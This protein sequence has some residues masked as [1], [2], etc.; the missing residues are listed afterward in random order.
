[1]KII[2]AKNDL[3]STL[4]TCQA[5]VVK[6]ASDLSGQYLFRIQP[7]SKDQ[8]E[9]LTYADRCN[10]LAQLKCQ[11]EPSDVSSFTFEAKRLDLWLEAVPDEAI[12]FTH[13]NGKTTAECSLGT[14]EFGSL[15]PS[16]FPLADS[17]IAQAVAIA[18]V[19][20]DHLKALLSR[21]KPFISVNDA[22]EAP[23]CQA[24]FRDGFLYATDRATAIGVKTPEFAKS[25]ISVTQKSMGALL[26]FLTQCGDADVTVKEQ[27]RIICYAL[28]TQAVFCESRNTQAKFPL[29][30]LGFDQ[31]S[32]YVWELEV[33]ALRKILPFLISAAPADDTR[34]LFQPG[35]TPD[36]IQVGMRVQAGGVKYLPFPAKKSQTADA[37]KIDRETF[38]LPYE[39]LLRLLDASSE[40]TMKLGIHPKGESGWCRLNDVQD[41]QE[42]F[43]VVVW[44]N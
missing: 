11:L 24:Q 13:Q 17:L 43:V 29:L 32:P 40:D 12:T 35:D 14:Q 20:A 42:C 33:K 25:P 1:M 37:Q 36:Y 4:R 22:K 44:K 31:A 27:E 9:V 15:D 28:G 19:K 8:V 16:S 23:L 34:V 18:T 26:Q 6:S 41:G 38:R 3:L 21:V 2:V 39:M 30:Q 5:T 10:T 7:G